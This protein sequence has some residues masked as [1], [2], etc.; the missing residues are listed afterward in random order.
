[1]INLI[2]TSTYA[3]QLIY[4]IIP[5]YI[6]QNKFSIPQKRNKNIARKLLEQEKFDDKSIIQ[7]WSYFNYKQN[8]KNLKG[9]VINAT[10]PLTNVNSQPFDSLS[11][12]AASNANAF[13]T[14]AH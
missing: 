7:S 12:A 4:T 8:F 13:R 14:R 11:A 1:M 3:V 10:E 2:I 6:S 5:N 9:N